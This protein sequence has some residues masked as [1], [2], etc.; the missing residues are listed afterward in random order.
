MH[1]SF[2]LV[3]VAICLTDVCNGQFKILGLLDTKSEINNGKVE[4]IRSLDKVAESFPSHSDAVVELSDVTETING[5]E[6]LDVG[7]E[8]VNFIK[9]YEAVTNE[10]KQDFVQVPSGTGASLKV[11]ITKVLES[12]ETNSES[13]SG[14]D[15][16]SETISDG[17]I[18][19]S[20]FESTTSTSTTT[21]A[22]KTYRS[23][24]ENLSQFWLLTE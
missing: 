6:Q 20:M 15:V 12:D 17:D 3:A 5:S 7:K 2:V 24:C 19:A 18:A 16:T 21:I 4:N 10:W 1:F 23:E 22:A 9:P 13:V 11:N 14:K 8:N